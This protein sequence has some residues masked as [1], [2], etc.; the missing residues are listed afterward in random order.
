MT[1]TQEN[2][3]GA[4]VGHVTD[5]DAIEAA[6]V[7]CLRFWSDGPGT[8]TTLWNDFATQLGSVRARNALNTFEE[9]MALCARHGR[10]PLMRHAR[11]CTCV[12]ADEACFANFVATAATGD[13][14]DAMLI[15]TLLVRADV[16]PVITALAADFGLTLLHMT[17]SALGDLGHRS[18][19]T[20]SSLTRIH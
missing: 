16:A 4:P 9:L 19:H 11:H 13:R 8:Q 14:D 17:L 20:Q 5:L 2:R 10:R 3:G 1:Q 6:A 18:D 15:A 12:G 7:H